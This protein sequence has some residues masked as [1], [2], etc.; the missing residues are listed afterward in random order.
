M[1]QEAQ[2]PEMLFGT[3]AWEDD[4]SYEYIKSH[5]TPQQTKGEP[6]M[7]N[8]SPPNKKAEL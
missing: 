7:Q 2:T 5:Y 6:A 3:W 1:V 8:P 4:G